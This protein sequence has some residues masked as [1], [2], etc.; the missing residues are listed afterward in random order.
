MSAPRSAA[1]QRRRE[2]TARCLAAAAT[3][4]PGRR[5][6]VDVDAV[7][8]WTGAPRAEGL[9]R[10]VEALAD[11]ME[12]RVAEDEAAGI[13]GNACTAGGIVPALRRRAAALAAAESEHAALDAS[14][15]ARVAEGWEP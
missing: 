7:P 12:R 9:A 1:H 4:A 10:A 8:L 5:V 3:L 11:E 15:R 14:Q 6:S 2:A 13:D